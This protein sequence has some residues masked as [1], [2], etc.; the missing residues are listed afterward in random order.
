MIAR[1][2]E[3]HPQARPAGETGREAADSPIHRGVGAAFVCALLELDRRRGAGAPG[4]RGSAAP[5]R[6][7]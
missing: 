6:R 7:A 1:N 2:T 3:S 5:A 4:E